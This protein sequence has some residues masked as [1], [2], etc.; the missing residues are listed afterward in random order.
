M[1]CCKLYTKDVL[2]TVRALRK[3]KPAG[4]CIMSAGATNAADF[5]SPASA[6]V[7]KV[8]EHELVDM[9]AAARK[10]ARPAHKR[11][12]K[13]KK[14]STP[15]GVCGYADCPLRTGEDTSLP[16]RDQYYCGACKEGKGCF[17]HLGCF[18]KCHRCLKA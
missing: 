18:F 9:G 3:N 17:F 12:P 1:K 4:L 10:A 16:A 15:R 6:H 2:E 7:Q 11:G 5:L 13:Q 14:V 8:A